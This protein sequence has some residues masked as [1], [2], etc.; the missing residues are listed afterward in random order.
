MSLERALP[1]DFTTS[2][3]SVSDFTVPE[4]LPSHDPSPPLLSNAPI[5]S[6]LEEL[7]HGH[8]LD[9][10]ENDSMALAPETLKVLAGESL[11][12]LIGDLTTLVESARGVAPSHEIDRASQLLHEESIN[13]ELLSAFRRSVMGG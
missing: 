9:Q 2:I 12:S 11:R 10:L 4:T 3:V 1:F 13:Q 8:A 5:Q 6:K 7:F